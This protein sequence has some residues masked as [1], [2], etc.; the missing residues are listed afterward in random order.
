METC[1]IPTTAC[2]QSLQYFDF[3]VT[4]NNLGQQRRSVDSAGLISIAQIIL[5]PS[6]ECH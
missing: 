6:R 4:E 2:L 5:K 3:P 1:I